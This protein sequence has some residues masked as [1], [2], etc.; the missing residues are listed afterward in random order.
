MSTASEVSAA[1]AKTIQITQTLALEQRTLW[2]DAV[3]QFVKNWLAIGGLIV[4]T[5]FIFA[6]FF[7]PYVAPYDFLDQDLSNTLQTPSA[8]H[9]LGTDDLGRDIFSRVLHGARTAALVSLSSTAVSLLIGVGV[10]TMAGFAGGRVDQFLMWLSDLVQSIPNLLLAILVNTAL[11][12]PIVDWFDALYERTRNPVFLNTLWLDF[13][14]VFGALALIGWPGLARLI[15]GQVL[16]ISQTD[17]VLAAR[18]LGASRPRIMIRHIVPNALG[19]LVVAVSQG[20]GGAILAE[21]GLSFLGMGVQPPNASWGSML[22]KSLSMWQI[23]P[24]LMVAP[25]VAIG[26]VQVAFIFFGDGLNDALN[27]RYRRQ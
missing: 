10:G 26:I 23:Y 24:H 3:R 18:A 12:R 5:L 9:W 17:Y 1:Q 6:A 19:P 15:R 14:L 16:S 21:S 22:N 11:K 20:M 27:P 13:V 2:Q 8:E 25:A 4:I 7:G